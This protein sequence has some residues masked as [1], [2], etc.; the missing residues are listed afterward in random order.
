MVPEDRFYTLDHQWLCPEDS[1]VTIGVTRAIIK[2]IRPIV[3]VQVLDADDEMK[4]EL[5]Y[6]EFEGPDASVQIYPP[7]EANIQEVNTR[8]VFDLER[9]ETDP[10]GEGWLLRIALQDE[11]VLHSFM[12]ARVYED[13]CLQ[14]LGKGWDA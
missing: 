11:K 14:K 2:Q 6:V 13:Y 1:Q 9:L 3:A 8:I 10:Y 4:F 5:P 12:T 7:I